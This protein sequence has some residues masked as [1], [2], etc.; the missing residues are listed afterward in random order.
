VSSVANAGDSCR[1]DSH[2]DV[3]LDDELPAAVPQCVN[4][5][6]VVTS[7]QQVLGLQEIVSEQNVWDHCEQKDSQDKS[8][9]ADVCTESMNPN[10]TRSVQDKLLESDDKLDSS[11]TELDEAVCEP[12]SE[13]DDVTKN[14][15]AAVKY[16]HT[17]PRVSSEVRCSSSQQLPTTDLHG[18]Q[19][20]RPS[21]S[22]ELVDTENCSAEVIV[23]ADHRGPFLTGS[24]EMAVSAP[25]EIDVRS[26]RQHSAIETGVCDLS[27]P[28]N[29]TV[30]IS[31]VEGRCR[32]VLVI[33]VDAQNSP[34]QF[35]SSAWQ[36]TVT[37]DDGHTVPSPQNTTAEIPPV[38]AECCETDERPTDVPV[39]TVDAQNSTVYSNNPSP[40]LE[41]VAETEVC[42]FSN[43]RDTA[44]EISPVETK[45]RETDELP[46]EVPLLT[47]DTQNS[48]VYS[49][50]ILTPRLESVTEADGCT[51]SSPQNTTAEISPGKVQCR[52]TEE[53]P[54]KVPLLMFD[55]QNS[56]IQCV[57]SRSIGCSPVQL[58]ASPASMPLDINTELVETVNCS[59]QTSVDVVDRSCSPLTCVMMCDIACSPLEV[60]T[61][62]ATTS[63][64][65]LVPSFGCSMQTEPLMIDVECSAMTP[66][67]CEGYCMT[68]VQTSPQDCSTKYNTASF[69][70][71]RPQSLR[72][73][74]STS[75]GLQ[76]DNILPACGKEFCRKT[77]AVG[78]ESSYATPLGMACNCDED[79]SRLAAAADCLE[80]REGSTQPHSCEELFDSNSQR[81]N[82]AHQPRSIYP[83]HLPLPVE[84]SDETRNGSSSTQPAELKDPTVQK[85]L[86]DSYSLESSQVL[87]KYSDEEKS[88][89]VKS[90]QSDDETYPAAI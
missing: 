56:P 17:S 43:L 28:N 87:P 26:E 8:E 66:P 57:T 70:T 72:T 39:P 23:N 89:E 75:P 48:L 16:I 88:E 12:T 37:R 65:L 38:K 5:S 20:E 2:T 32:E 58:P 42:T 41:S 22:A 35:E 6:L 55:A 73:A 76:Q 13:N 54:T 84:S 36:D 50:K 81:S 61:E 31:P 10:S 77:S 18:V 40:R 1:D 80:S 59:V 49:S 90:N 21:G 79:P 82:V 69:S 83:S 64:I 63:P 4:S 68:S 34:I 78:S 29:I 47:T 44:V 9:S 11:V 7:Q 27:S 52:E 19:S 67:R 3:Q 24:R 51:F 33:T 85:L 25:S 45:C 15:V 71:D 74:D 14:C 30:E 62:T 53:H 46:T 86:D 60:N